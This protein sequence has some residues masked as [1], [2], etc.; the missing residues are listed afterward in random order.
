M[1]VILGDETEVIVAVPRKIRVG[2]HTYRIQ[3]GKKAKQH[4]DDLGLVGQ[5]IPAEAVI[6]VDPDLS[7]T[8]AAEC[9]LHEVLHAIY[10]QTS[11]R[12]GGKSAE[13]DVVSAISPLIVSVLRDNPSLISL[14]LS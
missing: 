4:L 12:G 1:G 3:T 7:G 2:P 11:L 5:C 6:M 8:V 13:E 14:L 9:L 10:D